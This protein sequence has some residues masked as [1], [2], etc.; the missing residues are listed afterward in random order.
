MDIPENAELDPATGQEARRLSVQSC[1]NKIAHASLCRIKHCQTPSCVKMKRVFEHTKLCKRK[2]RDD[3]PICKQLIALYCY[4]AKHCVEGPECVV[5]YCLSIKKKLNQRLL[6]M[7]PITPAYRSH[8][9]DVLMNT[10]SSTNSTMLIFDQLI[11]DKVSFAKKLERDIYEG[12]DSS[13]NYYRLMATKKW[14][15]EM[16]IEEKLRMEQRNI[17]EIINL[18]GNH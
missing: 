2:T 12:S 16:D 13:T 9:N 18:F 4:H 14:E 6:L 11:N 10:I 1:I 8:G 15:I 3:C 7:Q 5:P 17:E